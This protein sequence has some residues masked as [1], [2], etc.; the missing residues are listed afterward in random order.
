MRFSF[1]KWACDRLTEDTDFGKKKNHL[2]RWSSFWFW[3]VFRQGKCHI[4]AQ[5]TSTHTLENRRTQNE[6]RVWCGFWSKSIIGPFLFLNVAA[7]ELRFDAVGLLF[8]GCRQ[9]SVTP[10]SQRQLTVSRTIF[11]QPLV[12]YSCTQSIMASR[13]GHLNE[14]IFHY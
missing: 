12:K 10:T 3:R 8:V 9:I 7:S 5:K 6:S 13:G 2:F 1:P 14:I 4:W 11:V